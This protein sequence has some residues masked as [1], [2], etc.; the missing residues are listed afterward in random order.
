MSGVVP[1]PS[2]SRGE[3]ILQP[4]YFT[5]SIFVKT[6]RD[7]ITTLIHSYHERY[8]KSPPTQPFA[9]FK[10]LW[11][12][13]GW[14]W[15]HF[16]VFDDR[17]RE[18]FLNM[19]HRLFLERMVKT[20]APFSR[21][22]ALFGFYT[23]FATQPQGTAPQLYNI[24]HIPIP[25]DHLASLKA[26]PNSLN[27]E[28]LLPLQPHVS[29]VLSVLLRDKVFFITPTSETG[30]L[31][32]RDLPREI[33]VEDGTIL[34]LDPNAPKKKGRP[35]KRDKFKKARL[36]LDSLDQWLHDTPP[37]QPLVD[38]SSLP[39]LEDSSALHNHTL[40]R[41]QEEKTYIL[42]ALNPQSTNTALSVYTGMAVQNSNQF[43]LGRLKAAEGIFPVEEPMAEGKAG[44]ARVDRAVN[45]LGTMSSVDRP[46]GALNLLEGAGKM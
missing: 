42:D 12:E 36:G 41:Y 39:S 31:N 4:N 38:G 24:V 7:D 30:S 6:V 29:Y 45:E 35:N 5:S 19:V 34:Q 20:E 3:L 32:P 27:V 16:M 46:G 15:M 23:F 13:Q 33:I 11:A 25:S 10:T 21:A 43:I 22:V 37:P 14:S 40:R 44:L 1:A 17:P 28:H 18:S 9:L 2:G 8:T 26:L